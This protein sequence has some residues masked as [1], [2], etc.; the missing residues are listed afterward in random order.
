VHTGSDQ[1]TGAKA[2]IPH[3]VVFILTTFERNMKH[4]FTLLFLHFA[5]TAYGQCGPYKHHPV[6]PDTFGSAYVVPIDCDNGA[7]I[8][9]CLWDNGDTDWSTDG[10]SVGSHS[11]VLY[12]GTVP[13]ETLNFEI[14]QLAWDL[15]QNVFLFAGEI[16]VGIYAE[17]PYCPAQ[18]FDGHH[19]PTDPDSTVIYLLQ[20]GVAIDSISPVSCLGMS[21]EWN[22]L[23]SGYSYQTYLVDR[24]VC[25]SYAY[26]ELVQTFSLDGAE[27][28]INTQAA[29][30][31]P[32]G[33]IEV[34]GV[35]PDPATASPPPMPLTGELNL[36]PLPD[37]WP[38]VGPAQPGTTG[39]WDGLA[40][41]EYQVVFTSDLLCS[42]VDTVIT[43]ESATGMANASVSSSALRLWPVPTTDVLHWSGDVPA[44]IRIMD[45]QGRVLRSERNVTQLNV[46]DLAP[47]SYV[48]RFDDGRQ[49]SFVKR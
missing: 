16:A 37:A 36:Y 39:Y 1:D 3:P 15:N 7:N 17:V 31:A 12:A 44:S 32:N 26:G 4:L 22:F 29:S 38:A 11:V 43:V 13:V 10:L 24:S 20:D 28:Q 49:G 34:F 41:G 33:S 5:A 27:M 8:T 45:L 19:C 9:G 30:G 18:I 23:P 2:T 42:P 25:G 21:H 14:E 47:G 48:L 46:S 40:P 6:W 35:V